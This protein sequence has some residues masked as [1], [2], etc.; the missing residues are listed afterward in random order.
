L[1]PLF[2]AVITGDDVVKGKPDPSLFVLA[3]QGIEVHP[4]KA[5]VCEDAVAGVQA[6]KAAGMR[7]LG[8]ASNGRGP[9]LQKA[10]AD[11]VV[12]DFTDIR[13]EILR[14]LFAPAVVK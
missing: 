1:R 2:R 12:P 8:I 9:V 7:C 14:P 6:A 10:G 5:L 13:L 11:M 4:A 3:A